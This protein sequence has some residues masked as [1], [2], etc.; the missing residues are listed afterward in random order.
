MTLFIQI[1]C[2][3]EEHTL[4]ATLKDLPS[5]IP[6]IDNIEILVIDDGSTDRTVEVA[7]SLGIS[8]ILSLGTNRGLAT[9]FAGGIQY[10]IE[11]GADIVVNTD[12]DNQ[13]YGG[14]IEKLV[15]PVLENRADMVVG[16]RPILQHTE[17][18]PL[19]KALQVLGSKMVRMIA[20]TD[21]KDAPS[22]FRAFSREA[23][24][25]LFI[26][27]KFS[28][29]IET[30][31]QASFSN[32]RIV[33][34]DIRV[35]PK[36]RESRLFSNLFTHIYK[37]ASTLL[38]MY[39]IYRPGRFFFW[40]GSLC[41]MI[42]LLLGMR[43]LYLVY[44]LDSPEPGRTYLPSLILLS[45]F[46]FFGLLSYFM[47]LLGELIKSQRKQMENIIYLQRKQLYEVKKQSK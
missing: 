24:M 10:C 32:L 23:C 12:A 27:S 35:N 5:E 34:A 11:H 31:V 25:R 7:R 37:S 30:L 15:L 18:S 39:I 17:F 46:A 43:F 28:Y 41:L 38:N 2:F 4:P 44:W 20:L 19:K 21:V 9:A 47:A 1:P 40:T 45:I 13:Y 33:S 22:G 16:C 14:D 26:Y 3:N 42:S 29:V 36:T 6:G 8:H